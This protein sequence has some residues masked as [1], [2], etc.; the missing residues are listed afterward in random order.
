MRFL[1]SEFWL[2]PLLSGNVLKLPRLTEN[3]ETNENYVAGI[4]VVQSRSC[5]NVTIRNAQD[6]AE[7]RRDCKVITGNLDFASDFAE[8]IHFDG[9]EEVQGYSPRQ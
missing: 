5:G 8:T 4:G 3:R 9:V 1:F 7:V 6:A 2:L